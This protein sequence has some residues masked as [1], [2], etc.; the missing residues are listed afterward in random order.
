MC[1]N[2]IRSSDQSCFL[3]YMCVCVRN[4]LLS[5]MLVSAVVTRFN[6]ERRLDE[7]EEKTV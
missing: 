7:R 4:C 1:G 5:S 6:P 3:Q 2:G